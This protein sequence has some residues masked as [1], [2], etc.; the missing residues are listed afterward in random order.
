[1]KNLS[2]FL[3]IIAFCGI[4]IFSQGCGITQ[5]KFHRGPVL[6]AEEYNDLGVTY[7][8][9]EQYK[10]AVDSYKRAIEVNE[11]YLVAW[12]NLGNVYSKMN[13]YEKAEEAYQH[14]L[15]LDES[16]FGAKN[17]LASIY[18]KEGE[19]LETALILVEECANT[20]SEYQ[21]YCLDT[22]GMVYYYS[23]DIDK[24]I[25]IMTTAIQT[26]PP[27]NTT[28]LSQQY[29]H[30]GTIYLSREEKDKALTNFKQSVE[31]DSEC[32]WAKKS[33]EKID[34]LNNIN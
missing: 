13:E 4:T 24:S 34:S 14:A 8:N 23:G 7:E 19:N 27:Q 25:E 32:E 15:N 11:N 29:F 20:S 9:R 28:L 17:N 10:L 22:L 26:T 18:I 33:Q 5:Y 1:M 16:A 2:N 6:S 30:L 3:V 21:S 12:I 31:V